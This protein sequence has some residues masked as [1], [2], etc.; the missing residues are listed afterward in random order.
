MPTP[1]LVPPLISV[2]KVPTPLALSTGPGL[3]TYN[4]AVT[5][6]GTV[7]MTNVRVTD[8]KCSSVNYISGDTYSNSRLDPNEVWQYGCS[9]TLSQTTTNTVTAM[10]DANGF[11]AI[12]TANATV[13]VGA[14]IVPPLIHLEKKPNIFVLPAGG[15]AVTYNYTVTNPGTAPLNNVSV[16]DNK[17]TGLPGRVVG[18]P[19]DLNHNNLLESNETWQFTCQTN[20]NQ[21]ITNIGTVEGSANGLTAIDFSPATVVVAPPTPTPA[22][23][24]PNTGVAPDENSIPW[25]MI[26]PAS[27]F[28]I[29]LS[30]YLVRKKQTV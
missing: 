22:P 15:G 3:V 12:D 16:T 4:Y 5:N 11:T 26:I 23:K 20:L 8:N 14:P 30:F 9:T 2:K 25:N 21:T 29:L 6:I 19:G 24:L 7:T 17:C 18:Q 10:G 27:I 28:G 13:V 1:A